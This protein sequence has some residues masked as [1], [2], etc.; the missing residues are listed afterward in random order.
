MLKQAHFKFSVF[1]GRILHLGVSGSIAAYKML[2]LIRAWKNVGINVSVTLT[3][4]ATNFVTPMSFS[5]LGASHVYGEM[6][7]DKADSCFAHLEPGQEADVMVIAP[8]TASTI[9]RLATG[10][11]EEMLAAQA[12]AFDGPTVISPAMHPKMWANKATQANWATLKERGYICVEPAC[13]QTAC[14]EQGEGRMT[15]VREI[16][17]AALKALS[18]QDLEGQTVLITIGP[19][20][21]FWDGVRFISNPSSGLMGA[22][23]AIAAYLRGATV[24]AVC[25]PGVP[26]LPKLINR[27]EVSTANEM[28]D[29]CQ[30]IWPSS[31]LGCFTAAVCDFKPNIPANVEAGEKLKKETLGA[32]PCLQLEATP[33]GLRTL[34]QSKKDNQRIIAFAAET[35]ELKENALKKMSEKNADMIVANIV[36]KPNTGFE[37]PNNTVMLLEKSGKSMNLPAMP[38]ADIAWRIWDSFLQL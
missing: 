14:G 24:Q 2:D 23:L 12:L 35:S 32:S 4:G 17:L 7:D 30:N 22:S 20:R 31:T 9:S 16:Y 18:P 25:G 27:H 1:T 11:A 21:E 26:W 15:D 6:F 19:T 3:K 28:L 33:D 13:G 34:S 38:K 8:A 10:S 37:S 36:G 5:A 29:V